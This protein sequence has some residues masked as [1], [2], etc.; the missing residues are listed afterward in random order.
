MGKVKITLIVIISV[1]FV[2]S[3]GTN[4]WLFYKYFNVKQ[5]ATEV[6]DKTLDDIKKD[7]DDLQKPITDKHVQNVEETKKLLTSENKLGEFVPDKIQ[8]KFYDIITDMDLSN[9]IDESKKQTGYTSDMF[10]KVAKDYEEEIAE[11]D[12][13]IEELKNKI[14]EKSETMKNDILPILMENELKKSIADL[15]RFGVGIYGDFS[16]ELAY[17]SKKTSFSGAFQFHVLIKKKIDLGIVLGMRYANK[18]PLD[19][20]LGFSVVYYW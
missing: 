10:N 9:N 14:D 8:L 11:R 13:L 4:V 1:L 6:V 18:T 16:T 17:F 12:K 5:T 20:F 2:A 19:P 3:I 7:V 15:V